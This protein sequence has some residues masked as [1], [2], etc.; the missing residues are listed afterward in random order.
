VVAVLV[1]GMTP[2]GRLV[3]LLLGA[4]VLLVMLAAYGR[5]GLP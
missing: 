2:L 3:A 5:I 4:L 1:K